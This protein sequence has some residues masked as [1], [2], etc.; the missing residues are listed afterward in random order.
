MTWG[1]TTWWLV[2][3]GAAAAAGAG[4]VLLPGGDA[5]GWTERSFE[6][7]TVYHR[8]VVDQVPA[9]RAT[10]DASASGLYREQRVSLQ[11]WPVLRW[12]W[13]IEQSV[14][15]PDERARDGDDFAARVYVIAAHPYL[16]WKTRAVC[17]VWAGR[18]A[19]GQDWPNPYTDSVRMLVLRS[20]DAQAGRWVEERRDVAA[21]FRRLFGSA[22]ERIDA[23]AVMTDGDQTGARVTAWYT[24][25]G[26][27]AGD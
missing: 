26:F 20:G 16:P 24:G 27:E 4:P 25:I 14:M 11:Q 19:V 18:S 13:R 22:P 1:V 6:G 7:H 17:Y 3:A 15:A 5:G 8:E 21:D 9:L 10:A 12:R 2:L 23:V